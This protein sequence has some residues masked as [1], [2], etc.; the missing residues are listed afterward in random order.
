VKP[1]AKRPTCAPRKDSQDGLVVRLILEGID[2]GGLQRDLASAGDV[3]QLTAGEDFTTDLH[4]M[5]VTIFRAA[6][7]HGNG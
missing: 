1:S 7:A 6:K 4:T 5:R 3:W 2:L